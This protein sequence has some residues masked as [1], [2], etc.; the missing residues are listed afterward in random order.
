MKKM[1]IL[2]SCIFAEFLG[3]SWSESE[4][5]IPLNDSPRQP[6][7]LFVVPHAVAVQSELPVP[8]GALLVVD[9]PA[10]VNSAPA[11]RGRARRH[12]WP[13]TGTASHT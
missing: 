5:L 7:T 6:S 9:C 10:A 12:Q 8:G 4:S 13:D 1:S 3:V 11:E 2:G